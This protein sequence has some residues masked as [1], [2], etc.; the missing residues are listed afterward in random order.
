MSNRNDAQA[1]FM[2]AMNS[3]KEFAKVNGGFVTKEDVVSYFKGMAI[4]ELKLQMIYGYLMANNIKVKGETQ[5]DNSFLK[6]MESAVEHDAQPDLDKEKTEVEREDHDADNSSDQL[7]ADLKAAGFTD[8]EE[9]D[10]NNSSKIREQLTES[11]NK[12]L[13]YEEDDKYISLYKE[14]LKMIEKLSESTKAMLLINIVEDNDKESLQLLSQSFLEE[15]ID[16]IE[17]FRKHGVLASDLIQEGN[18]AMMAYMS[19]KR[20]LHN[21]EWREKIKEGNTE[22]ILTVLQSIKE[23]IKAEIDG[24]IRMMIDEQLD[25]AKVGQKVLNKVN[26]INDWAKRLNQELGRKP[27]IDELAD[28]IGISKDNIQEAI[29]LSAEA[30]ED[31]DVKGKIEEV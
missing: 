21:F 23:E 7:S 6:M 31:I 1:S 8:E 3:L 5:V 27:T 22:D 11:I 12:N 20:F 14:D 13:N 15:I 29:Q 18:L 9:S 19:E 25:S 2:E 28:K 26:L 16:W 30:I 10:Q 24:S 4:D 17:P